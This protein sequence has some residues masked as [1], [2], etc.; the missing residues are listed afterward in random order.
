M[1]KYFYLLLILLI[2]VI[3]V[4]S[5][6]N[7][8]FVE[9]FN[10][11]SQTFV[12]VGDSILQNE[13]YGK[14]VESFLS[15]KQ[16]N[17]LCYAQDNA[18]IGEIDSQVSKLPAKQLNNSDTLVFLSAGGNNLL[19]HYV[20]QNQDINN[21]TMLNNMF[22]NYTKLVQNIQN[23]LPNAKLVLLDIYYPLNRHFKKFHSVIKEWNQMI[24]SF[25]NNP[26]NNIYDVLK[27]SEN[28]NEQEDFSLGIEPSSQGGEKIASLILSI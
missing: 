24:Y 12:L 26:N 5:L 20:Y 18:T 17:V 10:K 19:S 3:L 13:A 28:V 15:E 8:N 27:I 11:N 4:V 7:R 1:M 6:Q 23:K 16:K 2:L 22:Q 25:A 14:S 21:K 9:G